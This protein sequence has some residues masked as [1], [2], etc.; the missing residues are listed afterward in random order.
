MDSQTRSLKGAAR[1]HDGFG[2]NQAVLLLAFILETGLR[3]PDLERKIL[4]KLECAHG[5]ELD[6]ERLE[7]F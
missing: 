2:C 1:E 3:A 5:D 4:K 6:A 7:K